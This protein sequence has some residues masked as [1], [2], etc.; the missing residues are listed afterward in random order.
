MKW[1]KL[2][3]DLEIGLRESIVALK[4]GAMVARKRAERVD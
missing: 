2:K 1:T 3:A 4:K